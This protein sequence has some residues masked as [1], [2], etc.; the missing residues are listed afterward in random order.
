LNGRKCEN[1]EALVTDLRYYPIVPEGL[2]KP[3]KYL[4]GGQ[5]IGLY[6]RDS[7]FLLH[8]AEHLTIDNYFSAHLFV[9]YCRK[10]SM[11]SF[12]ICT[13]PQV[14]LSRSIQGE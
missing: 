10:I 11:R 4:E 13:H 6:I 12:I 9:T 14:S 2:R 1:W 5:N 7:Q 8:F 3:T